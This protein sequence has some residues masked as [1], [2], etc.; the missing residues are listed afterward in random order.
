MELQRLLDSFAR[1]HE[2]GQQQQG[3]QQGEAAARGTQGGAKGKAKGGAQAAGAGGAGL[4]GVKRAAEGGTP[5]VS[6][7]AARHLTPAAC[8][9]IYTYAKF[10]AAHPNT[11]VS[12]NAV[13]VV[14]RLHCAM[15]L[16]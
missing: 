6:D 5:L 2:G 16:P 13:L 8:K 3:Q 10:T 1:R 15:A 14:N 12:I 7:A 11:Q 4:A 9:P